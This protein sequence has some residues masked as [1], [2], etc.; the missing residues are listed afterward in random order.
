MIK[1]ILQ[2]PI[3][4]KIQT[5]LPISATNSS[6]LVTYKVFEKNE[7][8][9]RSW[10]YLPTFNAAKSTQETAMVDMR[11]WIPSVV[12]LTWGQ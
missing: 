10:R 11:L 7:L 9:K 2:V 6:S 3:G 5:R 12:D 4:S 8:L 1:V